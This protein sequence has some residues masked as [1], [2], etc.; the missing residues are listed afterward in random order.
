MTTE[1]GSQ[2]QLLTWTA[3]TPAPGTPSADPPRQEK[4][5]SF[6]RVTVWLQTVSLPL[7]WPAYRLILN[8][9]DT[10]ALTGIVMMADLVPVDMYDRR[11]KPGVRSVREVLLHKDSQLDERLEGILAATVRQQVIASGGQGF[12]IEELESMGRHLDFKAAAAV[13]H[14]KRRAARSVKKPKG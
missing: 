4:G 10:K 5:P 13:A 7:R 8:A 6:I 11:N 14:K 2:D 9:I 12:T 1:Q 3:D